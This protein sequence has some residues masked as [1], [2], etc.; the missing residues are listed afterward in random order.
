MHT[1][2]VL[3]GG[4]LLLIACLSI[5][6]RIGG[7]ASS[8][9]ADTA[10]YFIPIWLLAAG[11]NM[12][13]GVANAGYTIRDEIPIFLLIFSIPATVAFLVWWKYSS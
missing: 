8:A 3:A 13:I 2:K 11:I 1:L 10:K 9:F 6:Y 7:G 4:F 12:W 5:G